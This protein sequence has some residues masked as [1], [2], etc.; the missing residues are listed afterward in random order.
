[1][2]AI[3]WTADQ[4]AQLAHLCATTTMSAGE[5]ADVLGKLRG[6]VI[7]KAGRMGLVL[8]NAGKNFVGRTVNKDA[9]PVV[10]KDVSSAP[11]SFFAT[12]VAGIVGAVQEAIDKDPEL[13]DALRQMAPAPA[14]P[15]PAK[16]CATAS[17]C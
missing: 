14:T 8:P 4:E 3:R 15:D 12:C 5:M 10:R 17:A 13:L 1:M 6:A 16:R 11:I 9:R 7:G 2:A